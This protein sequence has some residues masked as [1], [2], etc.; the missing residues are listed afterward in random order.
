MA[1]RADEANPA[2]VRGG[3]A[4][5]QRPYTVQ[6]T[7]RRLLRVAGATEAFARVY[8]GTRE[9]TTPWAEVTCPA[10]GNWGAVH[11][12]HDVRA[13]LRL[14]VL[15]GAG[16]EFERG[17]IGRR[18]DEDCGVKPPTSAAPC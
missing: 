7:T 13:A 2:S 1:A 12:G 4:S 16:L 5:C 10:C 17:F 3:C 11:D 18:L 15:L 9:A 6:L 14:A 8:E